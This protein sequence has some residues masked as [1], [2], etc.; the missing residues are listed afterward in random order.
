MARHSGQRERWRGSAATQS[1]QNV[2]PQ[3][4]ATADTNE[5]VSVVRWWLAAS[6]VGE[7]RRLLHAMGVEHDALTGATAS[8]AGISPVGAS[9]HT[10]STAS[11][12]DG[13]IKAGKESLRDVLANYDEIEAFL[14]PLPCL[15]SML[16][17]SSAAIFQ[18]RA[19]A[20]EMESLPVGIS[21]A[22]RAARDG[23]KLKLNATE[24]GATQPGKN[25]QKIKI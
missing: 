6:V 16:A 2:W 10:S 25:T 9:S 21:L 19:C 11:T 14:R 13:V 5:A 20:K 22:M 17:A 18:P 1:A 15:H 4:R 12:D 3:L 24:C 8:L 7:M 23:R